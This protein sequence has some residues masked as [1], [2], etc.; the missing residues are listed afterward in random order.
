MF[1]V[2]I[3]HPFQAL[4]ALGWSSKGI[5][6]LVDFFQESQQ[7]IDNWPSPC[8]QTRG[9]VLKRVGLSVPHGKPM[10][11]SRVALLDWSQSQQGVSEN[12]VSLNPMVNDH[13]PN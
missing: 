6:S 8:G 12:S 4:S 11:L 2:I 5:K 9:D 10:A 13:Y 3:H 1:G 7:A